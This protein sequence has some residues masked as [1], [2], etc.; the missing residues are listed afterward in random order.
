MGEIRA[1]EINSGVQLEFKGVDFWHDP[2][3]GELAA[4][5]GARPVDDP[6][7]LHFHATDAEWDEVYRVLGDVR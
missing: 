2:D 6:D 5:V 1:R 3:L 4:S 7:D